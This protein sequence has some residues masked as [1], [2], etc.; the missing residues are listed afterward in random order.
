M[1]RGRRRGSGFTLVEL[2][3]VIVIIGIVAAVV[4]LFIGSPIRG[5][6]DQSRRAALT[7]AADLA[8]LR[9]ARDLRVAL[10]NS[11]RSSSDGHAIELLRTLDGDRY[12]AEPPGVED[13]RLTPGTADSAFDTLS[14][15]GGS[16][17][18]PPGARLAVYPLGEAGSQPY[19]DAVLTP[20]GMNITRGEVLVG[21][22]AESRI[23]L[24]SPHTFPLDSPS[25]RIFLV[26]GPV[27][28]LCA[29]GLLL[30]YADYPLQ[31]SQPTTRAALE[32]LTSPSGRSVI[33]EG[34]DASACNLRYS[35]SAGASQS[36]ASRRNAVA[37]LSIVLEQQG[38]RVRLL[39]QVHVDN[40]P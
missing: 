33:A 18:I 16:G 28:Y 23:T 30:R 7:D 4:G 14:P 8:L 13:D 5:F 10:P 1:R 38:E 31:S 26:E 39:R 27:S 22:T 9:M 17:G 15:L 40:S 37:R 29:D 32:G 25:R 21:G 6:L 34:V 11:V 20:Q 19:V 35:A 12:R 24:G 36:G 3:V 2:I